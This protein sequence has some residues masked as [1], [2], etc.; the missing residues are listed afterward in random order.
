ME[1]QKGPGM[2]DK[3]DR[4]RRYTAMLKSRTSACTSTAGHDVND[5][6]IM[7]LSIAVE[8]EHLL[9]CIDKWIMR[10]IFF[11]AQNAQSCETDIHHIMMDS[12]V[13]IG[14]LH[15]THMSAAGVRH[16]RTASGYSFPEWCSRAAGSSGCDV[17]DN[18]IL[19]F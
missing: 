17:F 5:A 4:Y 11:G 15:D 16:N 12:R 19:I 9:K 8:S 18:D 6:M 3:G 13:S 14:A 2:S 10:R 1:A 7:E